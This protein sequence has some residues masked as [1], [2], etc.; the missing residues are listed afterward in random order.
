MQEHH[1]DIISEGAPNLEDLG[2]QLT[3]FE[4]WTHAQLRTYRAK[5]YK[6]DALMEDLAEP[7]PEVIKELN[8]KPTDPHWEDPSHWVNYDDWLHKWDIRA[9]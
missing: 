6:E 3:P 1:S 2:V 8:R 7:G 9:Y 4:Y 5:R